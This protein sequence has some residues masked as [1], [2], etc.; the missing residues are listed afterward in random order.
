MIVL[1][2]TILGTAFAVA[3]IAAMICHLKNKKI[4]EEIAPKIDDNSYYGHYY[5]AA[6]T[7]I[8]KICKNLTDLH[9]DQ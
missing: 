6:G 9:F 1:T 5:T 4:S 2:V 8:K 3:L 7:S